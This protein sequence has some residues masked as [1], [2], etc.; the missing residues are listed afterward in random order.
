MRG[1]VAEF[2]VQAAGVADEEDVRLELA[3]V[4]KL[5]RRLLRG[6]AG[7]A[8]VEDRP[9][10]G[11]L[12]AE[13]LGTNTADVD[14]VQETWPA[15]DLVNVQAGLDAW[16]AAGGREHRLVGVVNCTSSRTRTTGWRCCY[17][18]P[19]PS[20]ACHGWWS[21]WPPTTPRSR[22]GSRPRSVS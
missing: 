20:R 10:F 16:L 6:V 13:H 19:T 12:L 18:P 1:Y 17:A 15:Y 4:R 5:A 8:R 21:R 22:P 2:G 11:R 14:V 9:S 7:A 3:D